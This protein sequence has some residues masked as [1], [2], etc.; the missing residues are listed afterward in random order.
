M[1]H[2]QSDPQSSSSVEE[3]IAVQRMPEWKRRERERRRTPDYK[4]GYNAGYNA[5]LLRGQ[6]K[7]IRPSV[8]RRQHWHCEE[9]GAVG[10][11]LFRDDDDAQQRSRRVTVS[12]ES[13]R[14]MRRCSGLQ[15]RQVN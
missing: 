3:S 2:S 5:G 9:C 8:Y 6:A 1:T 12:H 13:Q 14:R 7:A 4:A 15:V 11:V 10:M